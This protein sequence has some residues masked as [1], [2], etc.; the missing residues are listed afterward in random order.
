MDI[1]Y[2]GL[3]VVLGLSILGLC[4]GCAALRQRGAGS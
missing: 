4:Y 1:I 2:L 3:I